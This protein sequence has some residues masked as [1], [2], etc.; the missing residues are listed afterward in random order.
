MARVVVARGTDLGSLSSNFSR[1]ND[2]ISA[3]TIIELQLGG[4][5]SALLATT[6]F[7]LWA[8]RR[9]LRDSGCWSMYPEYSKYRE[10][11]QDIYML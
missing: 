4:L 2:G 11:L 1:Q 3:G 5:E 8:M 7:E 9:S 10:G 6:R